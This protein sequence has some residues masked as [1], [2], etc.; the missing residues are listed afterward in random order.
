MNLINSTT[1]E[2]H[3]FP[4]KDI[5]YKCNVH[6]KTKWIYILTLSHCESL[7]RLALISAWACSTCRS[8]GAALGFDVD[9]A[10]SGTASFNGLMA[11]CSVFFDTSDVD[12]PNPCSRICPTRSVDDIIIGL[13]TGLTGFGPISGLGGRVVADNTSGFTS[14]WAWFDPVVILTG[15]NSCGILELN[16]VLFECLWLLSDPLSGR[17][18]VISEIQNTISVI[19]ETEK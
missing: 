17:T 11:L 3:I 9:F 12:C 8:Q 18:T 5:Y 10:E 14:G 19:L 2:I 13:T 4:P 6:L 15:W 7:W 16:R 1:H